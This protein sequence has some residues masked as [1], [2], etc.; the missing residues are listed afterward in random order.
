M[1]SKGFV[2]VASVNKAFYYAAKKLAESVR[3][4]HPEANITFFTH[5]EWIESED[6]DLFDSI[7]TEGIPR[8]VRAKLWALNKT[9]YDITAYLDCDMMCQHE[10]IKDVFDLLPADLDIVFTKNRPYN[11]KL[12]NLSATEDMT[13]HCGFFV[14]RK[15]SK[16]MD[17]MGAWYTNYLDQSRPDYDI[18][19]YPKDAIK[20]DTFTMW[21]LLTYGGH[22]I[23]W[24]Y[25][26]EPD[27]RWNF[28]NG[29]KE[30]ELQGQETVLYHYTITKGMFREMD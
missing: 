12:T 20:W 28:V 25:I 13:C 5:E 2:I 10:D 15:N 18:A 4:F 11:A 3:D 24:G 7:V 27:A 14:Y 17:L 19:H 21:K 6:R 22:N 29:Y 1:L 8:H 16:T 23:K 9:P 30:S 26:P